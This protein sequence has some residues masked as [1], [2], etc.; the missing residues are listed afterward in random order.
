MLSFYAISQPLLDSLHDQLLHADSD[1][2]KMQVTQ[3]LSMYYAFNRYD[4]AI[5]YAK[6]SLALADRL[7]DNYARFQVLNSVLMTNNTLGDYTN[8]LTIAQRMLRVAEQL[9]NHRETSLG[10]AHHMIGLVNREM[11]NY[12]EAA[13]QLHLA[14]Q[15]QERQ[16]GNSAAYSQLA[17]IFLR[18]N[19]LDSALW[20]ARKGVEQATAER[21]EY[22]RGLVLAILGNVEQELGN[23]A[24]AEKYY[25]QGIA[26]SKEV[27]YILARL[28][29]NL[30]GLFS[31][32]DRPDSSFYYSYASLQMCTKANYANYALDASS[33]IVRLYESRNM[34]DSAFK[35]LKVKMNVRD[36]LFSQ[37]KNLQVLMLNF[38]ESQ[39]QQEILAAQEKLRNQIRTYSLIGAL[40][41]FLVIAFILFRNNRLQK[42]SKAQIEKAYGELKSTQ[43]QLIQSEK[44]AS[45]GE[46]TAGIAHEIQNP[47]NFVNN[48]SEVNNELLAEM[49]EEL[50]KGNSQSAKTI[51]EDIIMNG[52]KILT[53]GKRADAIVKSMLQHSRESK[54]QKEPTDLN[55]LADECLRLAYHGFRA[56]DQYFNVTTK[57]DLDPSLKKASVIPQDIGRLI[58][59]LLNNAFYAVADR[60]KNSA[61]GYVPTV[62]VATRKSD[63]MA[64]I[65]IMDNGIG[66]AEKSVDKIFQPFFTTKP[67]G[68]GTG[69]GLSLAYDIVKAHGGEINVKTKE[70]EG[71]E[72]VIH[73]PLV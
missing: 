24:L 31:V 7:K 11:E 32:T 34:L 58:L 62:A 4:S 16:K 47:L 51:A 52:Q 72:F 71:T 49:K 21:G 28:Y 18:K 43:A 38:G 3:R 67:T 63:G 69:L 55:A 50:D 46:L 12:P 1:S 37:Q 23:Y 15:F 61:N 10:M 6:L 22:G 60:N 25:R 57:M 59:N 9:T 45:L 68:Q 35:Y 56:K 20:Y 33:I 5:Y 48:F 54:G 53:H 41:V 8:A 70:G 27:R 65:I 2:S 19:Q 39:R 14:I 42:K 64:E 44:M 29:N 26:E 73:L 30:A 40:I 66:I 13:I 17:L 36:T